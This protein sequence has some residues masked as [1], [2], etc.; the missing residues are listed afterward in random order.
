MEKS[1]G[2]AAT[3]YVYD[4]AGNEL[5]QCSTQ[6]Q[7]VGGTEYVTT[8]QLGSTRLVMN[9]GRTP[10]ACH[11]YLPFGEELLAPESGRTGCY[12]SVD[13][14]T[15][16]FTG[17]ERDTETAGSATPS[18]LDYFVTRYYSSAQG[19]FTSPDDAF[20]NWDLGNP[21]SFNLYSYANNNPL[22]SVDEDGRNVQVCVLA[23]D[24]KSY[25][26][27]VMTDAE[28]KKTY[29]NNNGKN[30]VA[31][32]KFNGVATAGTITCGGNVCGSAKF[33]DPGIQDQS[34]SIGVGIVGGKAAGK[35]AEFAFPRVA[36]WFGRVFGKTASEAVSTRAASGLGDLTPEEVSQIQRVVDASGRPVEVVGSAARAVEGP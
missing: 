8:D 24:Q 25:S 21:Q 3:V 22:N 26:C 28:Y 10:V 5:A 1:T 13:G 4:A 32:P 30:G 12:A 17:K 11:D 20:E 34:A 19:R 18:G 36:A 16:K 9:A 7:V 6:A 27:W 15:Q 33:V 23:S 14:V 2:A 35:V 31:M 29:T